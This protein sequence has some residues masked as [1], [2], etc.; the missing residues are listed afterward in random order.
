MN[1]SASTSSSSSSRTSLEVSPVGVS[2]ISF[3]PRRINE[4]SG[5]DSCAV[6]V[7]VNGELGWVEVKWFAISA[8]IGYCGS[9]VNA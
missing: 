6:S 1:R 4:R 3:R 5:P 8:S 9:N 7:R 2:S